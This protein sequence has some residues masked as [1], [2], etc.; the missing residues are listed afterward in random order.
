[1]S[2]NQL[3]KNQIDNIYKN[4][5]RQIGKY[6]AIYS[7]S[8]H[9]NKFMV[10]LSPTNNYLLDTIELRKDF[11]KKLNNRKNYKQFKLAYFSSIEIKLNKNSP[12]TYAHMTELNRIKAM[13]H[14][15]HIHIQLFTDMKEADLQRIIGKID[16][17]LCVESLISIPTKK[18]KEYDYVLKDIKTIDWELMHIL[19]TQHK[20]KIIYTSSRKELANYMITKLWSYMKITYQSKWTNIQDKYSFI[21]K[22]KKNGELIM[23]NQTNGIQPK[24]VNQFDVIYIKNNGS[25]IYVKKN[26]L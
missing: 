17:S 24:N 4:Q 18:N 14:N 5:R 12:S 20:G 19:K 6:F 2:Y 22:L 11:F 21:L 15:F 3:S 25:Y 13:Q 16:S 8:G 1:M 7:E 9:L 10:T 26:V 23:G